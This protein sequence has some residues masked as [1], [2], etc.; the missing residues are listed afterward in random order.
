MKILAQVHLPKTIGEIYSRRTTVSLV[1]TVCNTAMV[2]LF[3]IDP[4]LCTI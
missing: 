4:A 1:N 3:N 2:T